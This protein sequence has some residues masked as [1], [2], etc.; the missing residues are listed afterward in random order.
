MLDYPKIIRESKS[1]GVSPYL[2]AKRKL[3]Y[4]KAKKREL[5]CRFCEHL[6]LVG[7]DKCNKRKQCFII[8]ESISVY[9]DV[10]H[11]HICNAFEKIKRGVDHDYKKYIK[12]LGEKENEDD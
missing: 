9:S 2:L 1:M 8:G 12:F 10:D 6:R 4:R 3:H 5:D 11:L 7:Y